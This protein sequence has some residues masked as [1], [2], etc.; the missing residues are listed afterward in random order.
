MGIDCANDFQ[1]PLCE[2]RA[3]HCC[4]CLVRQQEDVAK[5]TCLHAMKIRAVCGANLV[6]LPTNQ[7]LNRAVCSSSYSLLLLQVLEGL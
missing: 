7:D 3:E 4:V 2:I 1:T 5:S 6:T